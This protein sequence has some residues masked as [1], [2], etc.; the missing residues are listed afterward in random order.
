V[1]ENLEGFVCRGEREG[2]CEGVKDGEADKDGWGQC[3]QMVIC[4][5]ENEIIETMKWHDEA[6][7]VTEATA[8]PLGFR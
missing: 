3:Q 8:G 2:G 5:D 6:A 4:I 1:T 7:V